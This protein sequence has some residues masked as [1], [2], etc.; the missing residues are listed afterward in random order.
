MTW[1]TRSR[2]LRIITLNL[3]AAEYG[4]GNMIGRNGIRTPS[5]VGF[6]TLLTLSFGQFAALRAYSAD[7]PPTRSTAAPSIR[8]PESVVPDGTGDSKENDDPAEDNDSADVDKLL[9]L[10][11]DQLTETPVKVDS[12]L[13][14]TLTD[15]V[16]ESV[17]K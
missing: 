14:S 5:V 9:D 12:D 2:H 6:I 10:D 7:T 15:P 1:G 3:V 11:I 4:V 13:T 16:V 8:Q 17:S